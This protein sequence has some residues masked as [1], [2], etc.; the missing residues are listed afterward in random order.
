VLNNK[1]LE[2][3][4]RAA[5]ITTAL[6]WLLGN[7]PLTLVPVEFRLGLALAQRIVPYLGYVGAFIAW[8]WG[9]M[10]TFDKGA[11]P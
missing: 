11:F 4:K 7:V 6:Q 1:R 8:S 10:K 2:A 5:I 9:A 3:A